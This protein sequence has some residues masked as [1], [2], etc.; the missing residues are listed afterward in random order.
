MTRLRSAGRRSGAT[1]VAAAVIGGL[2]GGATG[3]GALPQQPHTDGS[4]TDAERTAQD[5]VPAV[6]PRPQS[7]RAHGSFVPVT[8][9]VTLLAGPDAD[10][11]ALDVVREVLRDAGAHTVHHPDPDA[12]PG[13]QPAGPGT[14]VRVGGA[15]AEQALH[16]LGARERGDLP[17][18][19]YRL[20]TGQVDGRG[21]VALAGRGDAGLFHAAQTLRQ[22]LTEHDGGTGFAG[23]LV[24]DW[25]A[26]SARGVAE[27][28][29]GEPWSHRER[30][31]QLDFLGRTKQNRYLYAPGEDGYRQARRWRDPY[32]A[33]RRAGFRELAQRARR[34]HVTLAWAV[35]PG[36]SLCFSS[37]QDRRAL[38]RK[39]DAM[40]A[41]GFGAFQLQ[42]DDVSYTE[43]HCDEDASTYGSGPQAAARAQADLANAVADHLAA[44]QPGTAPLSVLP[45]EYYQQGRTEYRKALAHALHDGV[46]VVWT[47]VGVVPQTIT[48][49]ELAEVRKAFPHHPLVTM[50]NYPVND[51]APD[52][53]FLGPVRGREPAVASGS[54]VLLSNAMPQ[55]LA[56]RIPLFTAADYAWNPH[57]YR[58]GT[59]WRAA[60]E[61][62]AGPD[63]D[64][65]AAV[66]TLAAN[67]AS[68][69]LGGTESAYLQPL[70][71]DFWAAHGGTDP[72]RLSDAAG[73]LRRA[74]AGMRAAREDVPEPLAEETGRWLD[75]LAR[76]GAAG[77]CA[78]D[79]LLA[80][81]RGDG[82]A[83]WQAQQELHRLD[84]R[85]D[86]SEVTVGKGVLPQF[87]DRALRA[88]EDWTGVRGKAF[89]DE[90]LH[91]GPPG[92]D[93]GS[94]R[95]AADGD[96]ATA[97]R[98]ES[99]PAPPGAP[100][101][102]GEVPQQ[103]GA[104][105][106]PLPRAR[107]LR[108][109][110]VLSGPHSGTR[111]DVQVH[112]PGAGWQTLG[113]LSGSG[114]T[115]VDAH[116]VE[117]DAIRLRW[118]DGSQAP[119]VHEITPW[120][121]DM[122][123]AALSL[124]RTETYAAI[125]GDGAKVTAELTA[126][127]PGDV[128]DRLRVEAPDGF[129]VRAPRR[130]TVPRGSTTK[131]PVT[132]TAGK[133]VR[134]GTYR[135]PVSFGSEHTVLTVHAFPDTGGPDLARGAD[136]AASAVEASDFPAAAVTDG[137]PDT[138][139]SSPQRRDDAWVRV[140][141]PHRA[142]VGKVVLH[143]QD[144]YASRYRVQ[145]SP[146]GRHWRTA[147]T[148]RKGRGGTE[149]VRMDA[150]ADTR[151]VRV[152]CDERGTRFGYSLWSVEVYAV[153]DR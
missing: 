116:G 108:A 59:A 24:R 153:R 139:W 109:V 4:V 52:R 151:F 70:L 21:T 110:T 69:I 42:F 6:W 106:A 90:A 39:L 140:K 77:E 32:P 10:P 29:Y 74:F 76:L 17:A 71:E 27:A 150:P 19:G 114:W 85:I 41:L 117:A 123:S 97:Y 61:A 135:V 136:A 148:V 54:A 118:Q 12:D 103:P 91:G 87:V 9:E 82:G 134:P 75:Q 25:P 100:R 44:R 146:D 86:D 66:R 68:S 14:V 83:A 89:G 141:L 122:P 137:D 129:T 84:K 112:V 92:E 101:G 63:G 50:D 73:R 124:S 45:T 128:E 80:Q 127:R 20:A 132:V 64:S 65:R 37:A 57:G 119:V 142:R 28:F 93:G 143:W 55:A 72:D 2:L 107:E 26:S 46:Q 126:R 43:W 35:S 96:P 23:V 149:S 94:L 5:G 48:G 81:S 56:S 51:F 16:T 15:S 138:R 120:Y 3:A 145:V 88:F 36:Q 47:G 130:L 131:V 33:D 121:A 62:A 49:G 60:V 98:A 144:A 11:Y 8:R 125:G 95:R 18:G 115:Q 30:L 38:L 53:L 58:P 1:A 78:L 104:V 67:E 147:A 113:H 111:A 40:R 105:T 133:D 99:A 22:L 34:N 7:I 102:R 152:R 79:M 13:A 31:A